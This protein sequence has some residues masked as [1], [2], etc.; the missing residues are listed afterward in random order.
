MP[1]VHPSV[2]FMA[3]CEDMVIEDKRVSLHHLILN[4]I[5]KDT[6]PFPVIVPQL[7]VFVALAEARGHAEFFLR[8]VQ[9]D[10]ETVLFTTK[11]RSHH[12]GPD[13]LK[14]HGIPFR[15]RNCTFPEAGL[16]WIQFWFNSALLAQ[17]DLFLR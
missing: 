13:P 2:R 4:L 7:C 12:F 1:K 3:I 11:K 6:P 15:V 5:A 17:Q 16:Y 14:A 9:A 8:I 10:S